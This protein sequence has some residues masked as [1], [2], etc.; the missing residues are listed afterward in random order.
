VSG[1]FC[2]CERKLAFKRTANKTTAGLR[3]QAAAFVESLP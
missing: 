1:F 3:K 2:A